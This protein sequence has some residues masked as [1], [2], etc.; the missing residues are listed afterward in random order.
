MLR[1]FDSSRDPPKEWSLSNG[2]KLRYATEMS[3]LQHRL[4][5]SDLHPSIRRRLGEV[6]EALFL[7]GAGSAIWF[8]LIAVFVS[9][10]IHDV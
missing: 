7:Y 5:R 8:A 9:A 2:T 1:R 3:N 6:I 4:Q 10:L